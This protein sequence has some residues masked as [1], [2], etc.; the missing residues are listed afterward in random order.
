[1]AGSARAI[2]GQRGAGPFSLSGASSAS[3]IVHGSTLIGTMV[4]LM[5]ERPR[6]IPD[7]IG[8]G[9]CVLS[10][11]IHGPVPFDPLTI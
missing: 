3:A 5:A 11:S 6:S 1:M 4:G 9:R 10:S 2:L 8:T 7:R